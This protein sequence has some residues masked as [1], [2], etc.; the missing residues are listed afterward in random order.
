MTTSIG[1][2]IAALL[3]GTGSIDTGALVS[4]LVNASRAPRVKP[5][6]TSKPRALN[7]TRVS[8]LASATSSLDTFS[9]RAQLRHMSS[10][11]LRGPAGI[12]RS[13]HRSRMSAL[14]GGAPQG[15]PAQIEVQQ[16][17]RR[18]GAGVGRALPTAYNDAVGLGTLTLTT[19]SGAKTITIDSS[20]NSLDRPRRRDQRRRVRAL[21]PASWYRQPWR[22]PGDE[23]REWRGQQL[24]R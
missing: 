17:R 24:S 6:I 1:T 11:S 15:L 8:A 23:G 16:A 5:S 9:S 4:Q 18:A 13:D 2:S 3:G 12:E 14:P 21:P 20:N 10:A 19:A 7:G 22:A